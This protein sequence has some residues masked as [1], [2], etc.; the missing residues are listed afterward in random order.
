VADTD[1]D[2][3]GTADCNDGCPQDGMKTAPGLCGCG[4]PDTDQGQVV[5]CTG[6]VSAL[7]H[8]YR[9]DGTSTTITDAKGDQDGLLQGTTLG[10]NNQLDLAGGSSN[11]FVD[12]PNGLISGLTD[13]TFEV[14]LTWSG[15][16]I[17]ER[18]FDFGDN[19]S[20]TEGNQGTGKTY[21]FLTP[22]S[23][24]AGGAMRVAYSTNG[25]G[26]ETQIDASSELSTTGIHHVVVVVDDTGDMLRLYLD[27]AEAGSKALSGSLSGIHDINNWLGRS[28]YS[29][30]A[31]FGGT[32]YEFRVYDTALSAGQVALSFGDGPD[33]AYLEP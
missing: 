13:A 15:G 20:A 8:R 31:E 2:N 5:S 22:R 17:W 9:F 7:V 25:S 18:I 33:P 23:S 28:Q 29:S 19:S 6:L 24:G 1:S 14:W 12:L 30:D 26:S 4:R 3:D 16:S 27:G 10:G 11:Q 21:L 32:L